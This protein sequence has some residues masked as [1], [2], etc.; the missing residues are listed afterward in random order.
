MLLGLRF[1]YFIRFQ[2]N[3]KGLNKIEWFSRNEKLWIIYYISEN[4]SNDYNMV[5]VDVAI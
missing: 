5:S 3:L 4:L 2:R 1:V